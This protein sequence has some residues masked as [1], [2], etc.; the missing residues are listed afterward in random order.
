MWQKHEKRE[1]IF[2]LFFF[3][4]NNNMK[5]A[6]GKVEFKKRMKENGFCK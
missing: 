3:L 5:H 2:L 4:S 1:E 6:N